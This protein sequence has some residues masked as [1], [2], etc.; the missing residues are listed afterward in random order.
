MPPLKREEAGDLCGVARPLEVA[1]LGWFFYGP[2][3]VPNFGL[4]AWMCC[5]SH[6]GRR[7]TE[8]ALVCPTKLACH[9]VCVL[10]IMFAKI[11]A[12]A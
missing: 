8:A 6:S 12:W 10:T 9:R 1:H 7:Y 4:R 11:G 2:G 3:L 5:E